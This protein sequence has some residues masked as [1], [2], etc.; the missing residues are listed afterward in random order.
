[1]TTS[2]PNRPGIKQGGSG[3][4][5]ELLLDL[6]GGEVA[7]A[8]ETT[9]IMRD[10]HMVKT[11]EKGKQFRFP[12]TWRTS[13]A[14]HTP[15]TDILGNQIPHTEI[16]VSPDDKLISHVFVADIDEIL[17]HYD[18]RA[19]YTAE[20]GQAL[21]RFYDTNVMRRV[22][23]AARSGALFTGDQGGTVLTNAG[24][25]T[26]ASTLINGLSAGKEQM[27][28]KDVPI[29][30]QPVYAVLPTSLWYMVA[31]SDKNLN[32]DYNGGTSSIR[33]MA[34]Q[35]IDGITI[36]KSNLTPFGTNDS[37]NA[38]IPAKYR[39]NFSTTVGALWT[40]YAVATAEV[41]GLSSQIVDQ[42][43][44]QGTLMLARLMVGTDPLRSKCAVELKTA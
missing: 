25:G 20:L 39:A 22:V 4:N 14:Y 24:Y 15:G 35:T 27:D 26:D 2:T 32:K 8:F 17:N 29:D 28:L 42:P 21:A 11:L 41:Q 10:K 30:T 1:M 5:Y 38:A 6:Y 44:K 43:D 40:P 23:Q 34:L 7:T 16:V 9:T 37:A 18:V 36:L 31:R 19:P 33:D 3:G 13:V 12:A